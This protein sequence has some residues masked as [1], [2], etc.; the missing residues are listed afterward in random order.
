MWV[1]H[2]WKGGHEKKMALGQGYGRR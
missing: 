2:V 1:W